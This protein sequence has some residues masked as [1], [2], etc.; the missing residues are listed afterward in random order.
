MN[1]SVEQHP[2][3][4]QAF[5]RE[6]FISIYLRYRMEQPTDEEFEV[7][8]V[9][10]ASTVPDTSSE[11][12]IFMLSEKQINARVQDRHTCPAVQIM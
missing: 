10:F 7:W 5:N 2:V 12:Q 4:F 6:D 3:A 8:E 1:L 9:P 11:R